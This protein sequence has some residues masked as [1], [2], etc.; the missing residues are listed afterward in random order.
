MILRDGGR[1]S[2]GVLLLPVQ[3]VEAQGWILKRDRPQEEP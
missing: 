3:M 1:K 2:D